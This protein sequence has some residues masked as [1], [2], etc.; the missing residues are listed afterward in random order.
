MPLHQV[1]VVL[2]HANIQTTRGYARSYDGTVAADYTRAMLSV[3]KDLG[4]LPESES[5]VSPAQTVAL[6]DALK[7]LGSL[8]SQQLDVLAQARAGVLGLAKQA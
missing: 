2:G 8:N 7:S 6:L 5:A 4:L 1:Q 3:E